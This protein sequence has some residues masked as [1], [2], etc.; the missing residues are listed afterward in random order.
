MA[1]VIAATVIA[2]P[3]MIKSARAAIESVDIQYEIASYTLGKSEFETFFRITLPLASPDDWNRA[4][5]RCPGVNFGRHYSREEIERI[6][7]NRRWWECPQDTAD[8][9]RK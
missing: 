1:A 3:L 4:A 6:R 5:V 2:L 7:R 8:S 9:S